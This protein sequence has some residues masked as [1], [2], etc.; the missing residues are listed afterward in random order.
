MTQPLYD[1]TVE[2]LIDGA[3]TEVT[4]LDDDARVLGGDGTNGITVQRGSTG[5]QDEP[6]P[7]D[8]RMRLLDNEGRFNNDNP[9]SD[10]Y[11]LLGSNTP[12]R[13]FCVPDG[14]PL[15]VDD[16]FARTTSSGWGTV[17]GGG[18]WSV[19]GTGAGFAYSQFATTGSVGTM[20][21]SE[22]NA[23]RLAILQS[24]RLSST[25][26][27]AECTVA[28]ATGGALEPTLLLLYDA[29]PEGVDGYMARVLINTDNSVSVKLIALE[30]S[31]EVDLASATTTVT[32]AA[33]TPLKIRAQ[34]IANDDGLDAT[35]QLKV[36]Q[37][38]SEPGTYNVIVM[39]SATNAPFRRAAPGAPGIRSGV[40]SGNSNA[41]P[42]TFTWDNVQIRD[43]SPR[44]TAEITSMRPIMSKAA[45]GSDVIVVDVEA[46]GIP[47]RLSQG[48][49]ALRS[50]AYRAMTSSRYDDVRVAYWPLEEEEGAEV[51]A[52]FTPYDMTGAVGYPVIGPPTNVFEYGA[53]TAHPAA[54]RM[55][56]FGNDTRIDFYPPAY[57]ATGE[58]KI[59]ALW[60]I[61]TGGTGTERQLY[62][63]YTTGGSFDYVDLAYNATANSIG[64]N[65]WSGGS[66]TKSSSSSLG[67]DAVDQPIAIGL[68][69]IESGGSI[70][71][72][73]YTYTPDNVYATD[74][75]W[76]TSTFGQVTHVTVGD[77]RISAVD[78]LIGYSF[79]HFAIAKDTDA[80]L[81]FYAVSAPYGFRAYDGEYALTRFARL[82]EEEGQ[83]YVLGGI[84]SGSEAM[85]P[86]TTDTLYNL[87]AECAAVDMGMLFEPRDSLAIGYRSRRDLTGQRA[88]PLSYSDSHL[89]GDF[90]PVVDNRYLRNDVTVSRRDGSQARY[91]IPDDDPE[92]VT[93]QQPPSGGGRWPESPTLN[94]QADSRLI[95]LAQWF[96]HVASWKGQRFPQI[97]FDL[98]R[99]AL[100]ADASA[101]N[102][103]RAAGPGDVF[104]I[105]VTGAPAWV[106]PGTGAAKVLIRGLYEE[107]GRLNHR[108]SAN[109]SPGSPFDV[110]IY[111]DEAGVRNLLNARRDTDLSTI[112]EDLTTTETDVTVVSTGGVVWTTNADDWST[113]LSGGTGLYIMIG[114]EMMRVTNISGASS[115]QMFTVDRSVNGIVRTHL[116]GAPVHVAYPARRGL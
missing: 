85:G 63:I 18:L 49:A 20:E 60:N 46:S 76:T 116:S 29:Q 79:G 93:T 81:N 44:F 87:L 114:G 104:S 16:A 67:T 12:V 34:Y 108:I 11:G 22:S 98:A 9:L 74:A 24:L 112:N 106:T 47:G 84:A 23:Y 96:A 1:V 113:T 86:Q 45:D 66:I 8:V 19:G 72:H 54:E 33:A 39:P 14:D 48:Q 78:H 59:T 35:L 21:V 26:I 31:A 5:E 115:P 15:T 6:S 2:M 102:I 80:F 110:A 51:T 100:Q 27:Y 88:L 57:T 52:F 75:T 107:F 3:W 10:L 4:R 64:L 105:D 40:A 94:A 56:T 37:G 41:K 73:V 95:F 77:R 69:F 38:G 25:E 83:D 103:V 101:T 70:I 7:T 32:H 89:S 50:V 13:A 53:Y 30:D 92:H 91:V 82:C 55:L 17:S 61:P 97:T 65:A 111:G 58:T 43:L 71:T 36:W 28:L 42:I 62:R 90:M 68:E 99:A 109:C